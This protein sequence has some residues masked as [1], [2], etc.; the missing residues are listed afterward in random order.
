MHVVVHEDPGYLTVEVEGQYSLEEALQVI[1]RVRVEADR[2]SCRRVLFDVIGVSG[3]SLPTERFRMGLEA[4]AVW[5]RQLRVAVLSTVADFSLYTE[6]VAVG[7][8][9]QFR[10]CADKGVAIRW[11]LQ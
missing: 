5:G 2:R 11:L 1:E 7:H 3:R 9:A 10:S 4:S 6:D 8:G